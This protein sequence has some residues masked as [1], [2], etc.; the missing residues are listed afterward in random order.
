MSDWI[1]YQPRRAREKEFYD[2]KLR[3]G[4]IVECCWPNGIGWYP[5]HPEKRSKHCRI[6]DYRVI[7]IRPVAVH[8]ADFQVFT[9]APAPAAVHPADIE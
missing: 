8:P 7:A 9:S 6:A 5:M 2:I 4:E 3:D 1:P